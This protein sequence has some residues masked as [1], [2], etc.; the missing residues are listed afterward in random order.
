MGWGRVGHRPAAGKAVPPALAGKCLRLPH[1]H[2]SALQARADGGAPQLP[3]LQ[4]HPG[5]CAT[6]PA[7]PP[8][9]LM[10]Q[11][12]SSAGFKGWH[13]LSLPC[14]PCTT[15]HPHIPPH[16]TTQVAYA[17][18][19]WVRNVRV[20]NADNALFYSWVHR[21]SILGTPGVAGGRRALAEV[22][23][24][25]CWCCQCPDPRLAP[26]CSQHARPPARPCAPLCR[27]DGWGD[28][29]ARQRRPP[30][31]PQRAPR[32]RRDGEPK[33]PGAAVSGPAAPVGGRRHMG[34]R[35]QPELA[36]EAW[37]PHSWAPAP[38][39]APAPASPC[40]RLTPCKPARLQVA[41]P[42]IHDITI[43]DSASMNV[44]ADSAGW[45]LN[46]DH[47]R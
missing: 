37:L 10:W 27:P 43:S 15:H 20:L 31:G 38:A 41:A 19:V 6:S 42:F 39:P 7:S 47:H 8:A 23:T 21:S 16:P 45:N 36:A 5:G 26:A 22:G 29:L 33:H 28:R 34:A 9:G 25:R 4:R 24:A 44:F 46:L 32:H 11:A 14:Q 18:N 3:R 17:S 40:A 35:L 1:P 30:Q 13:Q 2:R 12:T